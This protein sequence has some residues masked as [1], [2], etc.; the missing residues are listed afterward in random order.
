MKAG[1]SI[2]GGSRGAASPGTGPL[3]DETAAVW[4]ASDW[5]VQ[6]DLCPYA[7]EGGTAVAAVVDQLNH[8]PGQRQ[9][10]VAVVLLS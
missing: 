2:A 4:S 9:P 6:G 3:L 5:L 1:F 7:G 10:G 8:V